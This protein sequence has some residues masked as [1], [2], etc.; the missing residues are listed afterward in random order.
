MYDEAAKKCETSRETTKVSDKLSQAVGKS[1]VDFLVQTQTEHD[2]H[3]AISFGP[4]ERDLLRGK[5]YFKILLFYCRSHHIVNGR[6]V[7]KHCLFV[8]QQTDLLCLC[9]ISCQEVLR[10][11]VFNPIFSPSVLINRLTCVDHVSTHI[12]QNFFCLIMIETSTVGI[13]TSGRAQRIDMA[14]F[15]LKN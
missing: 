4:V 1:C 9:N 13:I 3:P 5:S 7:N 6:V 8:Y 10:C 11:F 15:E 14:P 2:A 12:T